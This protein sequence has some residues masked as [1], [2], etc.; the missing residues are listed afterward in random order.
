MKVFTNI[1]LT[2][3]YDPRSK[4]IR[5]RPSEGQDLP[6]LWVRCSRKERQQLQIGTIVKTDVK[7][8]ESANRKPYLVLLSKSLRQLSLF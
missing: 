2:T 7:M 4:R 5:V 1:L 8:I 3:L 6:M